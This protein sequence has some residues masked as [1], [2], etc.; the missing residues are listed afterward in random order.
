MSVLDFVHA[1]VLDVEEQPEILPMDHWRIGEA[2]RLVELG[3]A[4]IDASAVGVLPAWM[5]PEPWLTA[6][7][8]WID[9][10]DYDEAW[11]R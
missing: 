1:R 9:H 7:Q 11:D 4:I 6:A 3:Y 5:L 8:L 2:H 10:P